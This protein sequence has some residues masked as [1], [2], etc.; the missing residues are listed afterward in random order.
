MS[1]FPSTH[2]A[3]ESAQPGAVGLDDAAIA[4]A[5]RHAA[6]RETPW[7]RDLRQMV[8]S[9][10]GEEPPWNEPLGPTRPRGGPNGLVLREGR[11][12]A[13]WGDTGQVDMTFS[14]AKSYL[15]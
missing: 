9:D 15:S 7:S 8:E 4:A 6:E 11:I 12:V 14:V 5:A 10:F 13:E 2:P 3:W 1:Y